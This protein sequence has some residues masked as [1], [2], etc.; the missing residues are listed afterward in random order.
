MTWSVRNLTEPS[1]EPVTL[2]EAKLW[3]RIEDDDT[4]QDAVILLVIRAA[5]ERGEQITQMAFARRTMELRL[6]AF[7]ENDAP[8]W[9]PYP[10]LVSVQYITYG[11]TDGDVALTGSPESWQLDVGGMEIPARVAPLYGASWPSA[12][13]QAGSVRIGY[14]AGYATAS[15]MPATLRLWMQ[16]RISTFYEFREQIVMGNVN[17][18]PRDFVD[19][20]LDHYRARDFFA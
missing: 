14:T 13:A 2:T 6:D 10:P 3:C 9:L 19:G 18:L 20:L 5:R 4:A 17:A 15:K 12:V 7:P 11:T 8:I 16:A 1:T